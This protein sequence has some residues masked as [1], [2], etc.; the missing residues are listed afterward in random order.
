LLHAPQPQGAVGIA[1]HGGTRHNLLRR[2]LR[3]F[4]RMSLRCLPLYILPRHRAFL[5]VPPYP[6]LPRTHAALG[7]AHLFRAATLGTMPYAH[8]CLPHTAGLPFACTTTDAPFTMGGEA[9]AYPY[10]LYAPLSALPHTTHGNSPGYCCARATLAHLPRSH[11]AWTRHTFWTGLHYYRLLQHPPPRLPHP[12]TIKA[13]HTP[14]HTPPLPPPPM[15]TPLPPHTHTHTAT[16]HA[17]HT[18]PLLLMLFQQTFWASACLFSSSHTIL[19]F[20]WHAVLIIFLLSCYVYSG[21]E[22]L[23][24]VV[25]LLTWTPLRWVLPCLGYTSQHLI[26][27]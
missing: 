18:L 24:T 9:L 27:L 13:T 4:A 19:R 7:N 10:G 8:R 12:H 21:R 15:P 23:H 2:G 20:S 1:R 22:Q 25:R 17:P 26:I 11:T 5:S 3:F 14:P 6:A 16:P